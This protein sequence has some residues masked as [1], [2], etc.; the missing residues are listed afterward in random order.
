MNKSLLTFGVL[1]L[2]SNY[3]FSQITIK[4]DNVDVATSPLPEVSYV[5]AI[6]K[7]VDGKIEACEK[8]LRKDKLVS[9]SINP[10]IAAVHRAYAEHRPLSISPEMIWL[11][12][13]QGFSKHINYNSEKLRDKFVDFEGKKKIKIRTESLSSEFKKGSP[14]SPW[15]LAFP[16]FTDSIKKYVGPELH[17]LFIQSFSTTTYMEKA[18]FE[19][20]LMD[21]MDH[22]FDYQMLTMCGIPAITLEGTP[23]DWREI[24]SNLQKFKG[25]EI[26]HWIMALEP[27]IEEF[28]KA[29]KDEINHDF[30]S[31]IYKRKGGSGGPY[32]N[33]WI[34]KFF[35]YLKSHNDEAAKNP[36]LNMEPKE[37]QGLVMHGLK[38]DDFST[39][40]S[41]A[42]FIWNYYNKEYKM[43]FLAGFIG[44]RQD[45]NTMNLRPEIG[46]M[47]KER[48]K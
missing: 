28:Y 38:T 25:Y 42:D 21:G 34:I 4:C 30:W 45:K 23:K 32:I 5:Q 12:I 48:K 39:G 15:K 8:N 41:K 35:P 40:L 24:K 10:F 7:L 44:I 26:D 19:V 46:W 11:L 33:G 47:V 29:S 31:N 16:A 6:E 3:N 1:F 27:I 2:L 20:T 14:N 9:T 43:S 37:L 36:Y 13:C 18:A 22:Y 17:H